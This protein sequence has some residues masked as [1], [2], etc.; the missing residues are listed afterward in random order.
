MRQINRTNKL[1]TELFSD[2]FNIQTKTNELTP[3]SSS[4]EANSH[5][6]SQEISRLLWN[7]KVHCRVHNS[8]QRYV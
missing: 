3:W 8:P 6:V 2:M 7:P 1:I 5:S 4:W